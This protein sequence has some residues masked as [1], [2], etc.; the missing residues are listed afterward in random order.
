MKRLLLNPPEKK[1]PPFQG[2]V[3]ETTFAPTPS[4][5]NK[6]DK[7]PWLSALSSTLKEHKVDSTNIREDAGEVKVREASIDEHG[8]EIVPREPEGPRPSASM[9]TI[10]NQS[11]LNPAIQ[12]KKGMK[13]QAYKS[14]RPDLLNELN[15]SVA[16]GLHSIAKN[17]PHLF[18]PETSPNPQNKY[19]ST[20][21]PVNIPP[22]PMKTQSAEDASLYSAERLRV[23]ATAFQKF[24]DESTIYQR[25]LQDTKD[26]YDSYVL[27]LLDKLS[28]FNSNVVQTSKREIELSKQLVE[29]DEVHQLKVD[30]INEKVRALESRLQTLEMEKSISDTECSK[31]KEQMMNM[32]REYDE[33]KGTCL[34]LTNG[35]SRMED[36]HRSYQNNEAGRL[37]E[38]TYLR[39][40][41]Q[42]LNEEIER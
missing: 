26:T 12:I 33:M 34:T 36:E 28:M 29:R 27:E 1:G 19:G 10:N 42:K 31:A 22:S 2:V 21:S 6:S 3:P 11:H 7:L 25:F 39:A 14:T 24:I 30:K 17:Y 35:L 13:F 40:S 8:F 9:G 16:D 37:T 23:Y 41:E 15:K 20:T 5:S 4:H 32:K 18:S 38:L